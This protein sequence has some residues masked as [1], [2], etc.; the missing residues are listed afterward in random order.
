MTGYG[1]Q[2]HRDKN[3]DASDWSNCLANQPVE[4]APS[5]A[6]L[7][8]SRAAQR[9]LLHNLEFLKRRSASESR[10]AAVQGRIATVDQS[11]RD[12][13]LVITARESA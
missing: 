3:D 7:R 10:K 2:F 6:E 9:R 5:L 8:E 11:I 13:D 12:F 4:T 1:T